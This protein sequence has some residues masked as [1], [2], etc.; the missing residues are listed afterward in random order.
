LPRTP[1]RKPPTET[2][3]SKPLQDLAT[4]IQLTPQN[5]AVLQ[6]HVT[7]ETAFDMEGTL[8]TLT[9]DCLFEDMPTGT[10][11]RGRD[12]VRAYYQEW[13]SA[14]GNVPSSSR[15]YVPA[16]DGLIVETRFIGRHVG[17]YRGAAASGRQIDLP[18]AIFVSFRDGLMAG[19]RFYYDRL[20]L[21]SQ[22]S[23]A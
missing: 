18:V 3:P 16:D 9:D 17:T 8:A 10:V 20:S 13:W 7:A 12:G 2:H 6:L 1:Q 5:R 22:I 11:Y 19:E 23:P 15:L 21:L 14:F 4:M